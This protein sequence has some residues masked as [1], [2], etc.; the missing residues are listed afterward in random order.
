MASDAQAPEPLRASDAERER[1]VDLLRS[2]AGEGRLN[3]EELAERTER[4]L[5]AE[6]RPPEA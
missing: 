6:D 2:A 5:V 4:A 1:A 3:L